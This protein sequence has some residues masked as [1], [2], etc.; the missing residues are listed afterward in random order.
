MVLVYPPK[1]NDA[2]S[3]TEG[4]MLRLLPSE[5]LNDNL[6]DFYLKYLMLE[7][8]GQSY[9]KMYCFN[10]FFYKRLVSAKFNNATLGLEQHAVVNI[11]P[12]PPS[13]S[14]SWDF[15]LCNG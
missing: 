9:L 15:L 12:P 7:L 5:F 13:L 11:H 2:I 10:T 8:G 4:D 14:L 1:K 6:I 3:I